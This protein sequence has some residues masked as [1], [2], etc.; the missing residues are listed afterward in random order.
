[1]GK[2]PPGPWRGRGLSLAVLSSLV[3]RV[4]TG[5]CVG[6][7]SRGPGRLCPRLVGPPGLGPVILRPVRSRGSTA[8]A[9]PRLPGSPRSPPEAQPLPAHCRHRPAGRAGLTRTAEPGPASPSPPEAP[10][11]R[12]CLFQPPVFITTTQASA[13]LEVKGAAPRPPAMTHTSCQQSDPR[14]TLTQTTLYEPGG[15]HRRPQAQ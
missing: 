9:G 6:S 1:M 10:H 3:C 11:L 12:T 8:K 13:T 5:L 15:P 14:A 7:G 4:A 2:Q